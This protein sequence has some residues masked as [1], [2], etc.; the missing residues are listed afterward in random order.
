MLHVIQQQEYVRMDVMMAGGVIIVLKV[1]SC[2]ILVG[3]Y[4][5]KLL[6]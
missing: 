2:L 4:N 3:A 1:G 6:I 5:D